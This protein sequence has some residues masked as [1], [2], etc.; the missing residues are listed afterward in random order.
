MLDLDVLLDFGATPDPVV[1][2]FD[3]TRIWHLPYA[4]QRSSSPSLWRRHHVCAGQASR[5]ERHRG[6]GILEAWLDL[7]IEDAEARRGLEPESNQQTSSC[8]LH[9]DHPGP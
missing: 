4:G 8:P 7:T 9:A 5:L 1:D 6:Y 3:L 2:L